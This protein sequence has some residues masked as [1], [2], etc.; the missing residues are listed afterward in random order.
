MKLDF[1]SAMLDV[2]H[3]SLPNRIRSSRKRVSRF[4][5]DKILST[6]GLGCDI[7][8]D[9]GAG[10]EPLW[11]AGVVGSISHSKLSCVIA[12]ATWEN[13]RAVGVDVEQ[14]NR[15]TPRVIE[16][17]TTTNDLLESS[18]LSKYELS[19]LIFSAKESLFKLLYPDV[20][21]YFGFKSASLIKVSSTHFT[22]QLERSLG[23]RYQ[24]KERFDG[25]F[26]IMGEE[27][28]TL[29]TL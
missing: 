24:S 22:M 4:T 8:I 26:M 3:Y 10:G 12:I 27:I 1:S 17:I 6:L 20:K 25:H 18:V 23:A 15:I 5:R 19:T 21:H 2:Y 7:T 13:Y 14:L 9:R 11:P 28:I 16:R 29:M